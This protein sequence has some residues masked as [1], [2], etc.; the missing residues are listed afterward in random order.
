VSTILPPAPGPGPWRVLVYD[1]DPTDPKFILAVVARPADVRPT[2]PGATVD[3]LTAA[4]VAAASGLH[5]PALTPLPG[6]LCWRV[7][8]NRTS[9]RG[10]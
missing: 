5:R 8:E 7:D 10:D 4:W 9:P 1:G 2:S 3:D 6:A